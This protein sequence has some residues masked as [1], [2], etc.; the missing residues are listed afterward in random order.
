MSKTL[1]KAEKQ[2]HLHELVTGFDTAMLVTRVADGSLRSRP[3]QI[4][5]AEEDG[6]LYFATSIES[7][8][9][10]EIEAN[11]QVNVTLQ[12]GRRFVSITGMASIV[13]ERALIARLWSEAW[14]VW[15]PKGK[16]DP[17][18]CLLAVDAHAAEYWDQSGSK[19]LSYLFE[20]VSAYI[21]G[22]RPDDHDDTQNA[23]VDL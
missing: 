3:L 2:E 13:R 12:D 10:K 8:K 20:A 16:D 14:K 19:G 1:S 5:D 15:F 11:P 7:P 22:T 4:A 23:K 9:V 18:I 6:L 21:K 17:S